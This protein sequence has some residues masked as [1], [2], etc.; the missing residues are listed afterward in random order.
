VA[1]L[2]TAYGSARQLMDDVAGQA[3]YFCN[4]FHTT[5]QHPVLGQCLS[6]STNDEPSWS[7]LIHAASTVD[8]AILHPDSSPNRCGLINGLMNII[9]RKVGG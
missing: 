4:W 8:Y 5:E 6:K 9:L 7:L 1:G 2:A 3:G